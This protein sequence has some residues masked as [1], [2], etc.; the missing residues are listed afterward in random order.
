[1]YKSKTKENKLY[2]V[3]DPE[4][5]ESGGWRGEV[6]IFFGKSATSLHPTTHEYPWGYSQ[7]HSKDGYLKKKI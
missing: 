6:E 3:A 4:N 2:Q 1:M 5:S 7:Y